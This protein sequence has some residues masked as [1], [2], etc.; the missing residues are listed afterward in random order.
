MK[1]AIPGD[2]GPWQAIRRPIGGRPA[3]AGSVI[4]PIAGYTSF[5]PDAQVLPMPKPTR[6]TTTRRT[7]TRIPSTILF[8]RKKQNRR[9]RCTARSSNHRQ[10]GRV[11]SPKPTGWWGRVL[12]AIAVLAVVVAALAV[13][14]PT[15]AQSPGDLVITEFMANPNAVSDADGE[16][17]E[18]YNRSST[19]IDLDG[20][21]LRDDGS[22]SHTIDGA[23]AAVVIEPHGFLLLARSA[24][25]ISDG[26]VTV[27][28]VYDG[29]TL[30][31]SADEI[32][33]ATAAGTEIARI[34]YTDGDAAGAGIALESVSLEAGADGV[35][36]QDD[37]VASAT[38]LPNGDF[39]SPRMLGG[40]VLPVELA[41]F[42]AVREGR[43][44]TL[45]W[46][47][48]SETNN[49]GFEVL[50][51]LP[52]TPWTVAGFVEGAGTT[53]A[54]R[55]YRFAIESLPAGTHAFRLRQ[56]DTDGT[57]TLG[58]VER[59]QIGGRGGVEVVGPNPMTAGTSSAVSV[60]VAVAGRLQIH[61]FNLLGQQVQTV[62]DG[63]ASPMRPVTARV[64]P[65]NLASGMYL[66]Q[67]RGGGVDVT[68]RLA[69]VR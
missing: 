59:V 60:Q 6:I 45:Q 13:A 28:Y 64:A 31:N 4:E 36:T 49:A 27:D 7:S 11:R 22:N 12:P 34:T 57:Q 18:L 19:A 50:H 63:P 40:T 43:S 68:E 56:V 20:A 8:L 33:V 65:Q 1:R 48:I 47:T 61:L 41:S 46:V 17:V 32:V 9:P 23:G 10:V 2:G 53:V 52:K 38:E 26:S 69:V 66:L 15:Q 39:G 25:P 44:V 29:F 14:A 5:T 54:P 35:L 67:V 42:S 30:G 16:Y 37:L 55:S 58:P 3:A 62:Y 21:Q 51:R 24:D